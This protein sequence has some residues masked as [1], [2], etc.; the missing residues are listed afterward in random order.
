M[1]KLFS[2]VVRK[3]G[4]SDADK[5]MQLISVKRE[6]EKNVNDLERRLINLTGAIEDFLNDVRERPAIEK[7][8]LAMNDY[9]IRK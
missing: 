7:L 9:G 8:E 2:E 1:S 6:L 4:Q 5:V 3:Y